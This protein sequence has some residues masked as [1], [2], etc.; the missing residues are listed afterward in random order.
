MKFNAQNSSDKKYNV[1]SYN[2]QLQNTNSENNKITMELMT[3]YIRRICEEDVNEF[4]LYEIVRFN[5]IH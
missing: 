4:I 1:P 2:E 5:S 3:F